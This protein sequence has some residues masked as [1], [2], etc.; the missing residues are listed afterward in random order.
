MSK[1][2]I[3]DYLLLYDMLLRAGLLLQRIRDKQSKSDYTALEGIIIRSG[4][5]AKQIQDQHAQEVLDTVKT[6]RD[7]LWAER[8]PDVDGQPL[9]YR[10][11]GIGEPDSTR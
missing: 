7:R 6:Y 1:P 8:G 5:L 4:L 10:L 11:V 2:T 9:G 3:S